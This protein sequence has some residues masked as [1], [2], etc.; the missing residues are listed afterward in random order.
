M[1][2]LRYGLLS[3]QTAL[4]Q[5]WKK[6]DYKDENRHTKATKFTKKSGTLSDATDFPNDTI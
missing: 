6:T 2:L 3:V 5:Q 4:N 1:T